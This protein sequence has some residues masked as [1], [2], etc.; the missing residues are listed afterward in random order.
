[1][2]SLSKMTNPDNSS[3][4]RLISEQIQQSSDLFLSFW[5]SGDYRSEQITPT[6]LLLF[7]NVLDYI[8]LY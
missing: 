7:L 5:Y 2:L 4:A 6:C 1:M 3:T 8:E